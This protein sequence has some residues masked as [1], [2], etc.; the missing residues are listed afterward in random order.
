MNLQTTDAL[1]SSS[2]QTVN[3]HK[4]ESEP[5]NSVCHELTTAV[6]TQP[7]AI[8][9]LDNKPDLCAGN[10]IVEA[11]SNLVDKSLVSNKSKRACS[12]KFPLLASL[13]SKSSYHCI[14]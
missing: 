11:D 3:I 13:Q 4:I 6:N 5:V 14:Q 2:G 1:H 8:S 9:E 12:N 10:K 7:F